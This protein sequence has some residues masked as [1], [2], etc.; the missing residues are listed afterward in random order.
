[1]VSLVKCDKQD[2]SCKCKVG[3]AGNP[4]TECP[5]NCDPT[6]C[7][8]TFHCHTCNSGFYGDFCNQTCS[9]NCL[10]NTCTIQYNTATEMVAVT[11]VLDMEAIHVNPV[12]LTVLTPAVKNN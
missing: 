9:I 4:C 2:G 10:N 7:N 8:E 11:V 12:L 3:Y 1:M 5:P 6:G